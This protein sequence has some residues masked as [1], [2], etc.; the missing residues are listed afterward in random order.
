MKPAVTSAALVEGALTL[1]VKH[2]RNLRL[3]VFASK[4]FDGDPR[5]WKI[6][7]LVASAASGSDAAVLDPGTR[8]L[9]D[10]TADLDGIDPPLQLD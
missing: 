9:G 8:H 10:G 6:D 5:S 7:D 1:V 2:A 4:S 3:A